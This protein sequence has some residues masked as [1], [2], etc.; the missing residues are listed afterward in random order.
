[1]GAES[2]DSSAMVE[3]AERRKIDMKV[4]ALHLPEARAL[5]EADFALIRPDQIVAWRGN[6]CEA[7]KEI[8]HQILGSNAAS[9]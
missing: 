1:M 2:G 3:E 4:T 5:Y 8:L 7:A 6:S 9:T